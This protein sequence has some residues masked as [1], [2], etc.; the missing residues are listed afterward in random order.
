MEKKTTAPQLEIQRYLTVSTAHIT[1]EDMKRLNL[2]KAT[3]DT[4]L[5]LNSFDYGVSVYV[6]S[7]EEPAWETAK[8]EGF[9]SGLQNMLKLALDNDCRYLKLDCDGPTV[10]GYKTYN[11]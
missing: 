5:I 7:H 10:E 3:S 4:I 9:S 8:T 2:R 1:E 6:G 11:W